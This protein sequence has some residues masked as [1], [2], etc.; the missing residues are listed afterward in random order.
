[1][2]AFQGQH[3]VSSVSSGLT[4]LHFPPALR[5]FLKHDTDTI[6]SLHIRLQNHFTEMGLKCQMIFNI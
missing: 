2:W 6:C 5:L 1:M 3:S 4:C